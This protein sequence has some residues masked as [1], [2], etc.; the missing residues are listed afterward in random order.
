MN[1]GRGVKLGSETQ[2]VVGRC[3]Q[4]AVWAHK[5]RNAG[6]TCRKASLKKV[7]M[8]LV[9]TTAIFSVLLSYP[10]LNE[11][12][13]EDTPMKFKLNSHSFSDG[14][15]IPKKYT[16]DGDD[17]SPELHWTGSTTGCEEFRAD[18]G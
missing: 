5:D 10:A 8:R 3:S 9:V 4:L 15:N 11:E 14:G 13:R 18:R 6:E 7:Y 12:P 16:C 17:V 2:T 1:N